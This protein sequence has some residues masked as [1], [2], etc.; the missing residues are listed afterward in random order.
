MSDYNDLSAWIAK[1]ETL[2]DPELAQWTQ[3]W[4]A[5]EPPRIAGEHEQQR[6]RDKIQQKSVRIATTQSWIAI[7]I[8]L[9]ALAVS[10]F[11][12]ILRK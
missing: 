6:R 10:V 7:G 12:L 4:K 9:A 11:A 2:S 8:S 3:G 5:G 1:A